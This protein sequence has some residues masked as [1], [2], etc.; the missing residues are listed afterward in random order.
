ML[1]ALHR[2]IADAPSPLGTEI[3]EHS[4]RRADA[5]PLVPGEV[6]ELAFDLQPVSY[7]FRRGHAIRL[8]LAGA[9]RD[10]FVRMPAEGRVSWTVHRDHDRPSQLAL[11][12][13]TR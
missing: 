1:R 3:P 2:R 7:L 11:P 13:V 12:V 5:L 4:Y 10:H 8:A 6:A 9:D